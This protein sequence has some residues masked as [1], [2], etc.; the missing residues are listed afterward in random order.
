MSSIVDT[1]LGHYQH[2]GQIP[3]EYNPE[4]LR[5]ELV[6]IEQRIAIP[7]QNR[8]RVGAGSPE[9]AEVADV[10]TLFLRTDGGANT[11]LYVK[12]SGVGTDTGWV[13]K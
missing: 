11:T 1:L 12:E 9:G 8:I 2:R 10:G 6:N 4:W 7:L 5:R 3:T 13:G